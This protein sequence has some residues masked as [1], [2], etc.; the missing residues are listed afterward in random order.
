MIKSFLRVELIRLILFM[1]AI[2]TLHYFLWDS[3]LPDN[4]RLP[5][6]WLIYLFLIP[7]TLFVILYIYFHFKKDHTSVVKSFMFATII[8][9]LG[10][11]GFLLPWILYKDL[12]TRPMIVQFFVV[13]FPFLM[14]EIRFL[15]K[16]LGVLPEKIEKN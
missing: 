5:Q 2:A 7:I 6:V 12:T 4:Y 11:I 8:K 3:V 1:A 9:M 13:F 10:A 15:V 16:M 14:A